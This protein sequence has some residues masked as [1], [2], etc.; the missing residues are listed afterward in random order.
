M[1]CVPYT[2][3]D[4]FGCQN[5]FHIRTDVASLVSPLISK[6]DLGRLTGKHQCN[7]SPSAAL[8][9]RH[10]SCSGDASSPFSSSAASLQ[11]WSRNVGFPCGSSHAR[12]DD[13]LTTGSASQIK[14]KSDTQASS[15]YH[16][17]GLR[18]SEKTHG[19]GSEAQ[20]TKDSICSEPSFYNTKPSM[21][22]EASLAG[23]TKSQPSLLSFLNIEENQHSRNNPLGPIPFCE[24]QAITPV[25]S[26][27]ESNTSL[28]EVTLETENAKVLWIQ[29]S[30]RMQAGLD[31]SLDS[32][33][34]HKSKPVS[35][36]AHFY[37]RVPDAKMQIKEDQSDSMGL[38]MYAHVELFKYHA[39]GSG[40]SAFDYAVSQQVPKEM[41]PASKEPIN[42]SD[43]DSMSVVRLPVYRT[44][45]GANWSSRLTEG[46]LY[47]DSMGVDS[48]RLIK[49]ELTTMTYDIKRLREL[50]RVL[51]G[52]GLHWKDLGKV[53]NLCPRIIHLC[54]VKDI[55]LVTN[56][57]FDEVGLLPKDLSKV[58][59]RCPRLL[60]CDV[61]EQLLP[62]LLF[63][64]TLGYSNMGQVV[65]NN[66]T[67]L[68]LD[69]EKKLIPKMEYLES[70][71]FTNREVVSMVNRFPAL[72]NYNVKENLEPKYEYLVHEMGGSN[73]DLLAFPQY[74]G[75]SL[76][77]RIIPRYQCIS[78]QNVSLSI[79]AMLKLSEAEFIARFYSVCDPAASSKQETSDVEI[80][81][82][83]LESTKF[84]S[85]NYP[86]KPILEGAQR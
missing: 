76:L 82:C 28:S 79:Q 14:E 75:Y 50:V 55:K 59:K 36:A 10:D 72:F 44:S 69:V 53:F 22:Y 74:F 42:D 66:A 61:V 25:F 54:P 83:A 34:W 38:R 8:S 68:S 15:D 58:I 1:I 45:G 19:S 30:E 84:A 64:R 70:L 5:R 6:T 7:V 62:T 11:C 51:E 26:H 9:A 80:C 86:I 43:I 49:E 81:D 23:S 65:A 63:L 29:P 4:G 46:I 40:H 48:S 24:S 13:D 27:M 16:I 60:A 12:T 71:G 35:G 20:S 37:P 41:N 33:H 57:L 3:R 17:S 47:L 73:K 52:L 77:K 2:R 85:L 67:L 32:A 78:K 39:F 31:P 21:D 18:S 56:F